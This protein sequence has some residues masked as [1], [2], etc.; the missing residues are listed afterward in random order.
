MEEERRK[1]ESGREGGGI[2]IDVWTDLQLQ[3]LQ[4][5][6]VRPTRMPARILDCSRHV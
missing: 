5:S 6:G 2:W 4:T 1:E 3:R